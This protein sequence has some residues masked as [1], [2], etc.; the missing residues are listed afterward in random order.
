MHAYA[1][2]AVILPDAGSI[3]PTKMGQLSLS[4]KLSKQ[5]Q[6]AT[7]LP[8]LKSASLVSLGQLCDDDCVVL[9]N[10]RKMYAIKDDE[11]LVEGNR[12]IT[13]GLWDI[14]ISKNH[15]QE[16]NYEEP[17][18]HGL[19]YDLPKTNAIIQSS[20]TEQPK[21]DDRNFFRIFYGLNKL[22]DVNECELLCNKQQKADTRQYQKV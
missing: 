7:A 2:P 19:S 9:L 15:I 16:N 13:D 4:K 5:A 17:R 21:E 1:G 3:R 11:V 10:K 6:S 14:P 20:T 8:A 18:H 12:N 22:I